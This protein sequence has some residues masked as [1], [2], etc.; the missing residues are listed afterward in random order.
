MNKTYELR[1]ASFLFHL[2][3]TTK[4]KH[5]NQ[6]YVL[7]LVDTAGQ[8]NMLLIIFPLMVVEHAFDM[9]IFVVFAIW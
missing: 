7:E 2:A 3:F 1:N 6:E 4:L 5:N 8:V 9:S